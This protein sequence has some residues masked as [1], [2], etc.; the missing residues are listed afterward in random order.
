MKQQDTFI[1]PSFIISPDIIEF[2]KNKKTIIHYNFEWFNDNGKTSYKNI[3]IERVYTLDRNDVGKENVKVFWS[4]EEI[5]EN[6][7]IILIE[8]LKIEINNKENKPMFYKE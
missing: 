4:H 7:Q 5:P 6:I 2:F 3:N 8:M 1:I